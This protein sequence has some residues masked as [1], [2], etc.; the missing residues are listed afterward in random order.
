MAHP[1]PA[2]PG[3]GPAGQ[4]QDAPSKA[5]AVKL[6]QLFYVTTVGT[7]TLPV[8]LSLKTPECGEAFTLKRFTALSVI[9]GMVL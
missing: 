2:S 1:V 6:M 8:S 5:A 7:A 3:I 4:A 9:S